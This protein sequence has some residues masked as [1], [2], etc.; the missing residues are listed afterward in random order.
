MR[1]GNLFDAE[2]YASITYQ[3][4]K[5]KKN[6]MDQNGAAVAQ[7]AHNLANVIYQQHQK[8]T[9]FEELAKAEELAREAV[10]IRSL[11]HDSEHEILGDSCNLLAHILQSQGKVDEPRE[12]FE[13]YIAISIR[14]E[15]ADGNSVGV[16]NTHIG[17]FYFFL[18]LLRANADR[19]KD[20]L[21]KA[22]VYFQEGF[23]I[24]KITSS[25]TH[26]NYIAAER[27]LSGALTVLKTCI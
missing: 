10:R 19:K 2:R 22:K 25:P 18:S 1:T 14:N 13:R 5:D 27:H 23:R 17:R 15:G 24:A 7:G 9:N 26:P 3:N 8:R 16:G 6:G 20:Y 12:L 4:L 11:I 21:L